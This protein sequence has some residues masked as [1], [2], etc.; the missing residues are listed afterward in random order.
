MS[1]IGG[2]KKHGREITPDNVFNW[3]Q[4]DVNVEEDVDFEN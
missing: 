2:P 4:Y 1:R 3:S